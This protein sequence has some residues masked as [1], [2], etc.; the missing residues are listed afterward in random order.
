MRMRRGKDRREGGRG[1]IARGKEVGGKRIKEE[2]EENKDR[3][4][5]GGGR[6]E[7]KLKDED[8]EMHKMKEKK[9][10]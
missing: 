2:E 5:G 6:Q 8:V 7:E 1:E 4:C 9:E 3:R 10:G